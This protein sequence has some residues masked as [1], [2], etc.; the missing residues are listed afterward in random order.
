[1]LEPTAAPQS[2]ATAIVVVQNFSEE[3][4]RLMAAR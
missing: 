4:E 3:I 1:M 2:A